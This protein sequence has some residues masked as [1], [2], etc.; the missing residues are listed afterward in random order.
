MAYNLTLATAHL[1]GLGCKKSLELFFGLS[2][3]LL[4]LSTLPER[5]VKRH[6]FEIVIEI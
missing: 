5:R 1:L 6:D 2:C 4:F 3:F